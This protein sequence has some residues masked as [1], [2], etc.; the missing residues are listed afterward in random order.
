MNNRI[1]VLT[2][3]SSLNLADPSQRAELNSARA[4]VAKLIE[5]CYALSISPHGHVDSVLRGRIAAVR[6]AVSAVTGE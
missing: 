2:V 4:A 6:N 5:E 1:D 3:M